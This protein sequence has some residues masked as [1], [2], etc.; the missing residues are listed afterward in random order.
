VHDWQWEHVVVPLFA[1]ALA[2]GD[3]VV[4]GQG[5]DEYL[6]QQSIRTLTNVSAPRRHHL[7]LPLSILN[8]LVWRG[9]PTERTLAAPRV[10][11]FLGGIVAG[12]P[13][14]GA[15]RRLVLLGEVASLA[16][17]H[18]DYETLPGAPY[19]Y[20]E[21]LGCIW[22]ESLHGKLPPG[23][24]AMTM[25]ALLHRDRRGT[26]VLAALV[27]RS[28]LAA[29]AWLAELF[30]AVL[31]PLLHMLYRYGTVFSPHGENAILV[32]RDGVPTRLAI[33][34]FVDDV[35]VSDQPLPELRAALAPDVAAVLLAEPPEWLCQFLWAGLFVGHLRHLAD[36]AED[37][38]GVGERRFWT[39]TRA[40]VLG[41]Q[42][43]FPELADRFKTFDLLTPRFAKI[44]LNRNRLLTDGY[45]DR[46]ERPH[47]ATFGTVRN[48]LDEVAEP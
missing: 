15:D 11:E 6:P 1:P 21:L 35:N 23:E 44:C 17:P 38:L 26:P 39:M 46:P 47:A 28:G 27:E 40:A 7:K 32:H 25:A 41:Y 42:D 2:A 31:P 29:E 8:T 16:V 34:D 5:P 10:T 14:L 48:A 37:H 3:L 30:E 36:L 24:R 18:P 20:R 22:R 4:L 43:R 19:Q 9:L 12:D 13:F 33:K 45:A